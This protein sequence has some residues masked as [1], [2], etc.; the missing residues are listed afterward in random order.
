MGS[1]EIKFLSEFRQRRL[2]IDSGDGAANIEELSCAAEERFVVWVEAESLVAEEP[3]EV[4]KRAFGPCAKVAPR[5]DAAK[6]TTD[7]VGTA[8]CLCYP[9]N[10]RS[11]SEWELITYVFPRWRNSRNMQ[12]IR[13]PA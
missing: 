5:N 12:D 4:K 3:T 6:C 7:K 11:M 2:R 1:H 10:K 8:I 9:P 13:M